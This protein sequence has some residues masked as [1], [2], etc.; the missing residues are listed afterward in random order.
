MTLYRLRHPLRRRWLPRSVKRARR[1][2]WRVGHLRPWEIDWLKGRG[3]GDVQKTPCESDW[4]LSLTWDYQRNPS[5]DG[6]WPLR[7]YPL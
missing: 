7:W 1:S 6:K 5:S 2:I 3:A 4:V